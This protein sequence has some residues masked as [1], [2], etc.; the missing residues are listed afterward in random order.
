MPEYIFAV[1]SIIRTSTSGP[2]E[3]NAIAP[4]LARVKYISNIRGV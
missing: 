4:A 3:P 2:S 1:T